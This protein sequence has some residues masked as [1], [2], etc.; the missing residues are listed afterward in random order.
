MT[1][2]TTALGETWTATYPEPSTSTPRDAAHY[3]RRFLARRTLHPE[4]RAHAELV[5][6][7]LV[8]NAGRWGGGRTRISVLIDR[9][10]I[11]IAVTDEGSNIDGWGRG[12]GLRIAHLLCTSVDV[13]RHPGGKTVTAHLPYPPAEEG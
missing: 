2:E 3:L 11:T 7:H 13:V 10:G 1:T 6:W 4:L 8:D 5:A 9:D 12:E